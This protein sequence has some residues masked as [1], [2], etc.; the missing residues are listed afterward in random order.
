MGLKII[1]LKL[2][3]YP[4]G[5]NELSTLEYMLFIVQCINKHSFNGLR[6]PWMNSTDI[7]A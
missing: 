1:F 2:L 3:L 5:A 7:L 6:L 4:L